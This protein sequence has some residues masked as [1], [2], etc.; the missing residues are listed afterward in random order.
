MTE[1]CFNCLCREGYT[2][3]LYT[4]KVAWAPIGDEYDITGLP[5]GPV[6]LREGGTVHATDPWLDDVE[7]KPSRVEVLLFELLLYG[8]GV[9]ELHNWFEGVDAEMDLRTRQLVIQD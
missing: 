7:S 2:A 5:T 4:P 9:R 1:R 3:F 6:V 8:F